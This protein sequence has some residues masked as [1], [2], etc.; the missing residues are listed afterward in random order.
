[1]K[2]ESDFVRPDL[3]EILIIMGILIPAAIVLLTFG[4]E[5]R[6]IGHAAIALT[7]LAFLT[8]H[9]FTGAM[10]RGRV[11]TS[12]LPGRFRLHRMT[13][14][15]FGVF[16]VATFVQGLLTTA[17]HGEPVLESPHGIIGLALAVLVIVQVVPS[18]LIR[19]RG[20]LR[21]PHM[22]VGYAIVPLYL[23]QVVV[24]FSEAGLTAPF[25]D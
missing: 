11:K 5:S 14:I 17:G 15:W 10:V 22:V 20:R 19:N 23:L 2:G 9:I 18:I 24:G 6:W 7:G 13:S 12:R 21:F 1:M 8:A 3:P 16:V 4:T 25:P